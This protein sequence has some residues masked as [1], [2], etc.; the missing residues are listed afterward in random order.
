M[1]EVFH[2]SSKERAKHYRVRA[3]EAR[4]KASK[5]TGDL[6][7]IFVD[8]AERWEQLVRDV[9]GERVEHGSELFRGETAG[10]HHAS[11]PDW[12]DHVA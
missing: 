9:D 2:L 10:R 7:A 4:L 3:L 6:Q 5:H 8:F 12:P 1:L 11:V